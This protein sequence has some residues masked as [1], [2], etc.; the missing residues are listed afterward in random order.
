M[1]VSV[2]II[3]RYYDT[4]NGEIYD[5]FIYYILNYDMGLMG[6]NVWK[7]IIIPN[8]DAYEIYNTTFILGC[9][10][11]MLC[12]Y[13]FIYLLISLIFI[14]IEFVISNLI[15]CDIH[16]NS[17]FQSRYI[18]IQKLVKSILK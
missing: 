1:T 3:K 9:Y 18:A 7:I 14:N 13:L 17:P 8:N 2:P 4:R 6:Y 12:I 10:E 16:N 11:Y 5:K 15:F